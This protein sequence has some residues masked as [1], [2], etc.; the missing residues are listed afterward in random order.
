[1]EDLPAPVLPTIPIFSQDF[2]L[3]LTSC[4]TKGR[5][6]SYLRETPLNSTTPERGA[7]FNDVLW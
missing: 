1:M 6:L 4:K 7:T 3:K 5:D 2:V